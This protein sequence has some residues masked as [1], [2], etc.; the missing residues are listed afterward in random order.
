MG[1]EMPPFG[2]WIV[3]CWILT[4]PGHLF[5]APN[6]EKVD[7]CACFFNR[8]PHLFHRCNLKFVR[9]LGRF[10]LSVFSLSRSRAS[11]GKR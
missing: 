6:E 7:K 9:G 8:S 10:L 5:D 3:R 2:R 1:V 11:A 4:Q